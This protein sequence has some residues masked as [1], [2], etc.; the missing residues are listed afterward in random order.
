MGIKEVLI[1]LEIYRIQYNGM[2]FVIN[3]KYLKNN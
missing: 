3:K 1:Y 2:K